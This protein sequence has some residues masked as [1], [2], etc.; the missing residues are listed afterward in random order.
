M[1]ILYEKREASIST[2]LRDDDAPRTLWRYIDIHSNR[3]AAPDNCGNNS[4]RQTLH[5][6]AIDIRGALAG[7]QWLFA[8][9]LRNRIDLVALSFLGKNLL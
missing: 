2:A 3:V 5:S 6:V 9:R 8:N 7:R 1:A 4:I